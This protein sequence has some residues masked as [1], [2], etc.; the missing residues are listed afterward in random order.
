VLSNVSLVLR[1]F[2]M[3]NVNYQTKSHD[4]SIM[5]SR[6]MRSILSICSPGN[7]TL[8]PGLNFPKVH[9]TGAGA[10]HRQVVSHAFVTLL[11]AIHMRLIAAS[12]A[13]PLAYSLPDDDPQTQRGLTEIPIAF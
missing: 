6:Y 12:N 8:Q 11:H 7:K 2:Y 3:S 13:D 5:L 9:S 1:I 4:R 10:S